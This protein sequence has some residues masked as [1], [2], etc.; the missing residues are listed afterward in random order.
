MKTT[1]KLSLI[2]SVIIT[3]LFLATCKHEIPLTEDPD[4]NDTCG[5]TVFTHRIYL[6][7][8][9]GA[10]DDHQLHKMP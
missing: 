9:R 6:L 4:N 8:R 1:V 2:V 7:W 10:P 3:A 5:I